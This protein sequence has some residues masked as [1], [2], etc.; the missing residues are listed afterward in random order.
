MGVA[1]LIGTIELAQVLIRVMKLRGPVWDAI[2]YLDFG[3]LGY[4]IVALIV[5][6]WGASVAEC[7]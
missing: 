6:A 2:G 4:L 7:L 5:L 1:L 3:H